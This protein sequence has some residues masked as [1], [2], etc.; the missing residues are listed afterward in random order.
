MPLVEDFKVEIFNELTNL[1]L[2]Y[3]MLIFTDYVDDPYI[4][5]NS[6]YTS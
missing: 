3:F 2:S 4:K 1:S 6:G 5:F